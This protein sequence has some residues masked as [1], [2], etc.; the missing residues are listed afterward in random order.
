VTTGWKRSLRRRLAIRW[1]AHR[2]AARGAHP[3]EIARQTGLARD[4]IALLLAR[5]AAAAE[6][7]FRPEPA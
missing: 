1:Y 3:A 4:A 7:K 2:L 5:R 6:R